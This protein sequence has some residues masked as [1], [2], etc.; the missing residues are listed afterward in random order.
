MSGADIGWYVGD[1]VGPRVIPSGMKTFV[2]AMVV[3]YGTG[4]AFHYFC[5]VHPRSKEIFKNRTR[6]KWDTMWHQIKLSQASMTLYVFL[7][8]FDEWLIEY[9]RLDS[10]HKITDSNELH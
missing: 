4:G 2:G 5:Y 1:T 3:Y 7:P 9:I 6:P 8:V 10:V